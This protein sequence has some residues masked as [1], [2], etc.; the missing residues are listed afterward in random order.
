MGLIKEKYYFGATTKLCHSIYS[1]SLK[2]GNNCSLQRV[3]LLPQKGYKNFQ[4]A[5]KLKQKMA[6]SGVC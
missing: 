3:F 6:I 1:F 2:K 4:I 5:T